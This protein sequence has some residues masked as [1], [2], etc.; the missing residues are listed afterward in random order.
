MKFSSQEEYG[1]R[2]LLAVA[3]APSGS[4]TIPE[5]AR[6]EGLTEAYVGKLLMI[7]RKG[8]Y[9]TSTRGHN[10]GYALA[11]PPQRVQLGPLLGLLGG[12]LVDGEF[13]VRHAGTE[14]ECA[15]LGDC[16]VHWVWA[17]VQEAVDGV[18]N[19]LTLKDVMTGEPTYIRVQLDGRKQEISI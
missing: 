1:L 4:A 10:G 8:G 5:I 2:C 18:L 13:C 7:L 17:K 14:A 19:H 15:H 3:K 12:R 6:A 16:S 11:E 9:I